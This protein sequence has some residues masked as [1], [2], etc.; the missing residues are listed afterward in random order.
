MPGARVNPC[1]Y[2][3]T[4]NPIHNGHLMIAQA[5]LNQ[6]SLGINRIFFIPA[7]S[8]PHRNHE[9]D[10]ASA[11]HRLNMVQLA[12]ANNP[13]FQVLDNEIRRPG[14]SYTIDTIES[15]L[16]HEILQTPIPMIIGSDALAGLGTWHRAQELAKLVRFL[17][18]PRPGSSFIRE[19]ELSS[20]F[21][22]LSTQ[23]I[24]MPMTSLSS[25]WIR[26][27]I[28]QNPG[29]TTGLHYFVPESVRRYIQDNRLYITNS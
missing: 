27:L 2:F 7:G 23:S 17:Q 14:A 18:M 3:G 10:L 19:V 4:F 1:L 22:S 15:L 28:Q 24:E 5:V 6:P 12:T 8:P 9:S 25:S 29:N 26:A 20:G 21:T 16:A 11:T 13:A